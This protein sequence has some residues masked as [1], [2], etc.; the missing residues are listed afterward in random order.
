VL[1]LGTQDAINFQL[2]GGVWIL[3]TMP[4]LVFSLYTRWFHR[5]ALLIGWAVGML[6]GTIEAYHQSSLATK[7]FGSSLTQ[8]P[9]F[10]KLGYIALTA[11]VINL[12]VAVLLTFVFR[13]T[14]TPDGVDQTEP[15]DYFADEGDPRV[16]PIDELTEDSSR[17]ATT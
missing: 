4:A 3:Q 7:H 15:S 12:L 14:K 5:W 11:F 13:A 16:Q 17:A 8:V 10:G 6:Y 9:L 1:G 2:L